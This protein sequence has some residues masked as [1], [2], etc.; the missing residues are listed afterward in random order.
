MREGAKE[1]IAKLYNLKIDD[2]KRLEKAT[3]DVRNTEEAGG[4]K[5][6]NACRKL[7]EIKETLEEEYR[8]EL[9]QRNE[10]DEEEVEIKVR[11]T[12]ERDKQIKE[13]TNKIRRA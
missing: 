6:V 4:K 2:R 1:V 3:E 12:E 9:E 5:H 10:P 11:R 8:M 13:A 7:Q